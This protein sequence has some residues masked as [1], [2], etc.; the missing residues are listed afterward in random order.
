[1]LR[2]IAFVAVTQGQLPANAVTVGSH[3][4]CTWRC[5][6]ATCGR[7]WEATPKT[8]LSHGIGCTDCTNRTTTTLVRDTLERVIQSPHT[9]RQEKR[10][11][12]CVHKYRLPVDVAGPTPSAW[13]AERTS[14]PTASR[15]QPSSPRAT[16]PMPRTW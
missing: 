2:N 6:V 12:W 11:G 3:K 13:R 9:V 5:E 10:Y 7:V 15:Q 16:W 1:M 4:M 14:G 8:V